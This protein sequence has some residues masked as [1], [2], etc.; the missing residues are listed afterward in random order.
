MC[1]CLDI[2]S[3]RHEGSLVQISEAL[4]PCSFLSD[5]HSPELVSSVSVSKT[6]CLA[7]HYVDKGLESA[8]RLGARA[9]VHFVSCCSVSKNT[10]FIY[11][12]VFSS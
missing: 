2:F 11:F 4:F 1:V 10:C 8:C 9:R 3:K 5:S 7:S 12:A 6:L